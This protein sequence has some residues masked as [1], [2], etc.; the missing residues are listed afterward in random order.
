M[1][2]IDLRG[3]RNL[4]FD[5]EL[6][7][8]DELRLGGASIRVF[9]EDQLIGWIDFTTRAFIRAEDAPC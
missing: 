2:T 6:E 8:T 5:L 1:S 3:L 9:R 7:P 4:L